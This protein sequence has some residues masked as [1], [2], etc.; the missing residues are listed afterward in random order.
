M[1]SFGCNE[2]RLSYVLLSV[3]SMRCP[4]ERIWEENKQ[5]IDAEHISFP[6]RLLKLPAPAC[7][8]AQSG[9][10]GA[11]SGQI[12]ILFSSITLNP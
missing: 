3:S 10:S 12:L 1:K 2:F 7:R 9:A 4:L 11:R 6:L 5:K 8:Q